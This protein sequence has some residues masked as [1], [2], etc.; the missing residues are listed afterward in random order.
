MSMNVPDVLRVITLVLSSAAMGF[1][2][3]IASGI[4]APPNIPQQ[5]RVILG[6]VM[7]LYGAYRFVVAYYR[8]RDS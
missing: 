3:V 6:V 2:I 8:K 5:F 1:G 4:A 7:I